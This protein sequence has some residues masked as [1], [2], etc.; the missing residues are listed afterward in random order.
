MIDNNRSKVIYIAGPISGTDD[1]MERFKSAEEKIRS[2]GF[3]PVNPTVVSEPLVAA[4]CEYEEFMSVTHELLK[5]CGAI[6]LLEEWESSRGAQREL[7]YALE[8]GYEVYCEKTATGAKRRQ[9]N[10]TNL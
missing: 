7:L 1:Y 9:S 10:E 4:G 5:V 3:I 8:N 2:V 6:L